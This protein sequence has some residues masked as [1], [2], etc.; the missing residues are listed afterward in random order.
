ME[1]FQASF[2]GVL[3]IILWFLLISFI[4]RLVARLALPMVVRKAEQ[5]MREKQQGPIN[6]KEGEVTIERPK[7]KTR[8]SVGGEYVDYVEIRD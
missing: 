6:R 1:L 3:R 4:I 7:S 5:A 2:S 8:D